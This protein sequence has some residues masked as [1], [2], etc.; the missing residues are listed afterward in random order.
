MTDLQVT[1]DFNCHSCDEPVNVTVLY[2]GKGPAG[3]P[4]ESVAAVNVPCPTCAEINQVFFEP[5][6]TLRGVRPLRQ[7]LA[8]PV[9]SIN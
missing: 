6:G 4:A 2:Q 5:N 3:S 7:R 9:P 8:L 1:L